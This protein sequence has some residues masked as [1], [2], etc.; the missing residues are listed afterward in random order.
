MMNMCCS[1]IPLSA[2]ESINV[3]F[4]NLLN[5]TESLESLTGITSTSHGAVCTIKEQAESSISGTVFFK[6][7]VI[8]Y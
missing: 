3:I 4:V 5:I 1:V 7:R 8:L 6:Q 2:E